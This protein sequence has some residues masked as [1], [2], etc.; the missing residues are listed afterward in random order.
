MKV[1]F[2][3]KPKSRTNTWTLDNAGGNGLWVG[4][5]AIGIFILLIF[6]RNL[7][8]S[9]L[10]IALSSEIVFFW[11]CCVVLY[12]ILQS[13]YK[14]VPGGTDVLGKWK[15]V[16]GKIRNRAS[17]FTSIFMLFYINIPFK[18]IL[19]DALRIAIKHGCIFRTINTAKIIS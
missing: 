19:S 9:V 1:T 17:I 5:S 12:V 18:V 8:L 4:K 7:F 13:L 16:P 6:I 15:S 14:N 3:D 10:Y 2:H 11:F